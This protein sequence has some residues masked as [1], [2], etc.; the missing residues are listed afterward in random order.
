MAGSNNSQIPT[1]KHRLVSVKME[2]D[3]LRTHLTRPVD[4]GERC[5]CRRQKSLN[6]MLKQY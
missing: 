3:Y 2:F 1:A 6:Q 5:V 4:G